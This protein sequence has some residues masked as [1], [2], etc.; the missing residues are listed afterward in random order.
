MRDTAGYAVSLK[1]S[2]D[3]FYGM[4]PSDVF[5]A[6]SDIGWVVGHSYIVYAPLLHGCTSVLYEGKPVG[7]PD[8]GAFWRVISEH[9]VKAM[10]TAPTAFRVMKQADPNAELAKQY[11]LSCMETLFVAGE[12]CD[13]ETLA[14]CERALPHIPPPVDHWWQTELG[15][16]AVG[17]AVGLGRCPVRYG[18]CS[19]PVP[20]YEIDILDDDGNK[21]P[22]NELGNMA[23]KAPLPPGTMATI[24]NDDQ[25]YIDYFTKFPGYYETG[26]AA[27]IDDDGYVYIMGRT[28]DVINIAGHRLSTG[29]MEEVLMEHP[30]VA[31]CAVIAV[32]DDVKGQIPA[33][34]VI[35]VAGTTEEEHET[36]KNELIALVREEVGPVASFKKVGIV[37]ALPKTRSGKILRGTMSKIANGEPYK[38]TP[39]VEDVTIF[40]YLEPEILK[41]LR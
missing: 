33:G 17:N 24:Y 27:Y 38:I 15:G 29:S 5:W 13:P 22:P 36:V 34:L 25:R 12:H 30:K 10:F 6:A 9:R 16:P 26:D 18:S 8:A 37:K 4:N 1:Y 21:A 28:D 23:I 3:H 7:T 40:D 41:L 19:M 35:C 20:G 11:D 31:D 2:M 39:T 32:K 14:W